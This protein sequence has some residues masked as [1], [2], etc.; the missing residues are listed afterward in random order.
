[1]GTGVVCK[2]RC[3]QVGTVRFTAFRTPSTMSTRVA[4]DRSVVSGFDAAF[5]GGIRVIPSRRPRPLPY[6]YPITEYQRLSLGLSASYVDIVTS[7]NFS[8]PEAIDW[9]LHNGRPYNLQTFGG[10]PPQA[11]YDFGTKFATWEVNAGWPLRFTQ[12]RAICRSR[13]SCPCQRRPT[14]CRAVKFT[15]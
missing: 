15:Y 3:R 6:G 10:T 12:S 11:F 13:D 7:I 8:A 4:S 2:P 1:V 14:R 5:I 9:V